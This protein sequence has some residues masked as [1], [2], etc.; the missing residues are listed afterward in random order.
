ML[1]FSHVQVVATLP[2][3][4]N[5][6]SA[7]AV[8]PIS[9][10]K[11]SHS[12]SSLLVSVT[13]SGSLRL[14]ALDSPSDVERVL[15]RGRLSVGARVT[16]VALSPSTSSLVCIRGDTLYHYACEDF[17]AIAVAAAPV[18]SDIWI[19]ASFITET[20]LL[21]WTRS[22]RI[23]R[24]TLP[25][26]A[27][28]PIS[29]PPPSSSIPS[30]ASRSLATP[31]LRPTSPAPTRSAAAET[32]NFAPLTDDTPRL[33]PS[34]ELRYDVGS[35]AAFAHSKDGCFVVAVNAAA[36]LTFW[37]SARAPTPLPAVAP[38]SPLVESP[39]GTAKFASGW[40]DKEHDCVTVCISLDSSLL[41]VSGHASGRIS[42]TPLA[43]FEDRKEK[44]FTPWQ[45][46]NGAVSAL[47]ALTLS[48]S[49]LS[50]LASAGADCVVKVWDLA[51]ALYFDFPLINGLVVHVHVWRTLRSIARL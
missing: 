29:L 22:G 51:Y 43:Q 42:I 35:F 3:H 25:Q 46:H 39:N 1:G 31:Q 23:Y 27:S 33:T 37:D 12:S 11:E 28:L 17:R 7:L 19:G 36:D 15:K 40:P 26:C 6:V 2:A 45:A 9:S 4:D 48:K 34:T 49:P 41:I 18:S 8:S 21:A 10:I 47:C 16:A 38:A 14:S 24:Y 32:V 13:A 44:P 5:W 50:L 30:T 20:Q